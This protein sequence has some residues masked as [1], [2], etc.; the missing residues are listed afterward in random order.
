MVRCRDPTELG[1]LASGVA[2]GECGEGALLPASWAASTTAPWSCGS[3]GAQRSCED[4]AAAVASVAR[5]LGSVTAATT[6]AEAEQLLGEA[7]TVLH[8][9]HSL[10]LSLVRLL[11]SLYSVPASVSE[12]N[13]EADLDIS[14]LQRQVYT[15]SMY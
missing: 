10:C 6:A 1:T 2:C 12:G 4:V 15:C 13:T 9:Q 7:E 14:R 3:C 11:I 5:R 8:P